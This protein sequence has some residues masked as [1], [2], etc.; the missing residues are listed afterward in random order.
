MTV[1]CVR[2]AGTALAADDER[3]QVQ[4]R[5][6]QAATASARPSDQS[7]RS[8]LLLLGKGLKRGID[9][10]FSILLL[11]NS[12]LFPRFK[13]G[14]TVAYSMPTARSTFS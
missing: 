14:S 9:L 2:F 8:V 12:L 11:L 1:S 13:A 6:G 3:E 5:Q 4:S 10:S 7:G